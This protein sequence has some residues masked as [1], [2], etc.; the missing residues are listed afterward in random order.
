MRILTQYQLVSIFLSGL[1]AV[2]VSSGCGTVSNDGGGAPADSVADSVADSGSGAI[3]NDVS[4]PDA[5]TSADAATPVDAATPADAA[6]DP[7]EPDGTSCVAEGSQ[8]DADEV[9]CDGLNALECIV[10]LD[11]A[12]ST[13]AFEGCKQ[14][15]VCGDGACNAGENLCNCPADC[16]FAVSCIEEG[17]QA[18]SGQECCPGLDSLDC[19]TGSPPLCGIAAGGCHQCADCGDGVCAD[20]ENPCNCE[21]DCPVCTPAGESSGSI[22]VDCCEGLESVKIVSPNDDGVCPT[23]S[24][25]M[26][27]WRCIPCGDTTCDAAA[28]ENYCT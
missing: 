13:E 28:G 3:D 20:N 18:G 7:V 24:T 9:C 15:A 8:A 1:V 21:E 5:A 26:D 25:A 10:E 2:V 17:G 6:I 19:T 27:E 23:L 14:C 4:T 16:E 12:C 22:I 11:A